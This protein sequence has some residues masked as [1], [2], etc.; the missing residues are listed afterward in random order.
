MYAKLISNAT[1]KHVISE[2]L[3][4]PLYLIAVGFN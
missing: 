1:T 4:T 3:S 2:H